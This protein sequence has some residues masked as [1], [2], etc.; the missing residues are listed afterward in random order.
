MD[1][2]F[3]YCGNS[4][5]AYRTEFYGITLYR[6]LILEIK[7]THGAQAES[8]QLFATI[9]QQEVGIFEHCASLSGVLLKFR[10]D[11]QKT[12]SQIP[13]IYRNYAL[14][15]EYAIMCMLFKLRVMLRL[16][17]R[18]A[19]CL[20]EVLVELENQVLKGATR[21]FLPLMV[22]NDLCVEIS[23]RQ[24]RSVLKGNKSQYNRIQLLKRNKFDVDI[25]SCQLLLATFQ[26]QCS[27]YHGVLLTVNHVLSSIYRRMHYI[28]NEAGYILNF[29]TYMQTS[30]VWAILMLSAGLKSHGCLICVCFELIFHLCLALSKLNFCT[31]IHLS[32]LAYRLLYTAPTSRQ[33]NAELSKV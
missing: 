28:A 7:L 5:N 33:F 26:I 17:Q 20:E 24:L 30:I 10:R 1:V 8:L 14:D 2:S 13:E 27:D 19:L 32:Q 9:I 31:V 16:A 18:H 25:A 12:L 11:Q 22:I 4:I 3:T 6:V 15:N 21:S 23:V 29:R